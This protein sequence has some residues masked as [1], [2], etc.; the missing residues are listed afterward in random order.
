MKPL[1]P[2][3]YRLDAMDEGRR[4]LGVVGFTEVMGSRGGAEEDW[5]AAVGER[6][7]DHGV[8]RGWIEPASARAAYS[9]A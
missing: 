7:G 8:S 1:K 5:M 6:C 3:P 4:P 9:A 2:G